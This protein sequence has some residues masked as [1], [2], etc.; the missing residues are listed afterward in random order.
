[1]R[2]CA[3]GRHP[4]YIKRE[5]GRAELIA[6]VNLN[7]EVLQENAMKSRNVKSFVFSAHSNTVYSNRPR[8]RCKK[9]NRYLKKKTLPNR[10]EVF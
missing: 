7:K 1:M 4:K 6:F 2:R 10:S 5:L 9:D 3:F 8:A